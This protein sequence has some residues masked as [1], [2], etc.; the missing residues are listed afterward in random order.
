MGKETEITKGDF[1]TVKLS[2]GTEQ[3]FY[4][5][6]VGDGAVC[7]SFGT[8]FDREWCV[9]REFKIIRHRKPQMKKERAHAAE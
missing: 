5:H 6:Y 9:D 7:T 1:V 3:E 4:V 2:D 8:F